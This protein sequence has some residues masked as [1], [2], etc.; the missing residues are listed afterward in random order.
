M[1]G[2]FGDSVVFGNLLTDACKVISFVTTATSLALSW[3][4]VTVVVPLGATEKARSVGVG[5]RS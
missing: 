2:R 4:Y 5:S 1:G 3:A